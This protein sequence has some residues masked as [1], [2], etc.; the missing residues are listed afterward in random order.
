MTPFWIYLENNNNIFTEDQKAYLKSVFCLKSIPLKVPPTYVF[1]LFAAILQFLGISFES[2]VLCFCHIFFLLKNAQQ[3]RYKK[4]VL[5]KSST[6]CHPSS[7]CENFAPLKQSNEFLLEM[8]L[9]LLNQKSFYIFF[10]KKE[11]HAM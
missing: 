11:Q 2:K 8:K 7:I 3:R 10:Y 1:S 6:L 5:K 9:F 4:W